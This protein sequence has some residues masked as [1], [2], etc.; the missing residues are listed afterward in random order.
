ME[1]PF[2]KRSSDEKFIFI[3]NRRTHVKYFRKKR[4]TEFF[5]LK[6]C[7]MDY[8]III[9][10]AFVNSRYSRDSDIHFWNLSQNLKSNQHNHFISS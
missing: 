10:F 1:S 6:C 2:S 7:F 8:S 5:K 9:A 4:F 3:F